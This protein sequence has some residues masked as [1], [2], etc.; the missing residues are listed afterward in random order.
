MDKFDI[1]LNSILVEVY[2]NILRLEEQ[3]L[4]NANGISLSINE[5][6]LIEAVGKGGD[7]GRTVSEIAEELNITRPSATVAVNK[8]EK[9]GYLEKVNSKDDGRVVRV[10]LTK[11]GEVIDRYHHFYHSKMVRE[12]SSELTEEEK[13]YLLK[14]IY[15]L[16]DYFK[17][18]IGE[19]K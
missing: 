18:G 10:H 16:N 8:L 15:K 13:T 7:E 1:E 5:M 11:E 2:H 17:K 19:T 12:I 4:K 14:A 3:T 6:H 9:K